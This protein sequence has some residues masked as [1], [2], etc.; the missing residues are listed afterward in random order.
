MRRRLEL[1]L[2]AAALAPGCAS[3]ARAPRDVVVWI[4]I[5]GLRPDYVTP[6]DAPFLSG[7]LER[8]AFTRELVPPF[9]SLTFP[10][11][12]TQVTG[13]GA[14]RHGITGN[15]FWDSSLGRAFDFPDD[16]SLVEAEPIWATAA[17]QGRRA[18]VLDWPLSYRERGRWRAAIS[19]EKF[20]KEATDAQRLDHVIDAWRADSAREPLALVLGYVVGTDPPGHHSGPASDEVRR[21][22]RETDA[23]LERFFARARE[24]FAA[25]ASAGDR[26]HVLFTTDHGMTR[27]HTLVDFDRLFARPLPPEVRVVRGSTVAHLFLDG[28]PAD[29]RGEVERDVLAALGRDDALDVYRRSDLPRRWE[30]AH[31]TRTGDV[32][33]VAK[34]GFVLTEKLPR[35]RVAPEE[36]DGP[37]GMHGYDP[38]ACPDMLGLAIVWSSTGDVRRDLGRVD[39]RRLHPTIARLLGIEPSPLATEPPLD[40]AASTNEDAAAR[41]SSSSRGANAVEGVG[42]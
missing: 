21:R 4:S 1:L 12:T 32:V 13:V 30:F 7:L 39:A 24:T 37:R 19:D 3:P 29:R 11:H 15:S 28:V 34:P 23:L 27:V 9:P 8:A 22:M 36:T 33:V 38:A 16:A 14:D 25:K 17:R 42:R 20:D 41:T 35:L 6:E 26:L 40:L 10:S 2:A 31:P 5:D 18:A